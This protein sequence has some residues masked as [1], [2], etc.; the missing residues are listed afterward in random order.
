[1]QTQFPSLNITLL[2][3]YFSGIFSN[4]NDITPKTLISYRVG[5][6]V[7]AYRWLILA[8]MTKVHS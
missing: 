8:G 1:M 5:G 6:L 4:S 2:S 7:D 3:N